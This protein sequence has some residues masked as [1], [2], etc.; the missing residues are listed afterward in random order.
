MHIDNDIVLRLIQLPRQVNITGK[1]IHDLIVDMGCTT[2]SLKTP[3]AVIRQIL[4]QHPD[5]VD[6]WL[7]YSENKRTDSGWYVVVESG[8]YEVGYYSIETGRRVE[9]I[10]HDKTDACAAFIEHE[11]RDICTQ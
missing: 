11:I 1:P 2:M 10:Y 6:E 4:V 8:R 5:Y 3:A 9:A 7:L